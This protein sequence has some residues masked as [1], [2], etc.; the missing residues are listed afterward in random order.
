MNRTRFHFAYYILMLFTSVTLMGQEIESTI[1]DGS[2]NEYSNDQVPTSI[3][4]IVQTTAY[5]PI[6]GQEKVASDCLILLKN[7]GSLAAYELETLSH[8]WDLSF[9][10]GAYNK[11]DNHF[12]IENA[13]L[14]TLSTQREFLAVDV[15]TGKKYWK[16][17][18]GQQKE[19]TKRY[20]TDG[21]RLPIKGSLIYVA[22]NNTQLYAFNKRNGSLVWNYKLQ[23][24]YNNYSPVIN[25][26]Y[27]LIS[28]APWVYCFDARTGQAIWQRGFGNVPMYAQLQIDAEKAFT[29][30]ERNKI[31]ALD[32]ANN[33]AIDWEYET[34]HDSPRIKENTL[35]QNGVYYFAAR[36][37]GDDPATVTALNTADGQVVWKTV[38]ENDGEEID[39]FYAYND[40]IVGSTDAAENGFFI[41]DAKNGEQWK[42]ESPK[43]KVL[44][45]IFGMGDELYFITENFL[46]S[47]NLE[48]K[49]FDYR[50]FEFDDQGKDSFSLHFEIAKAEK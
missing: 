13:I 22:S 3:E 21:Q 20:V 50:A 29:A 1:D 4:E 2:S 36:K 17:E 7:D 27:L 35:L 43:E 12:R 37:N 31:Y 16:T 38:L 14:Y 41:I 39:T 19:I 28:N 25:D 18:I 49:K 48:R 40:L 23:F 46:V 26:N 11:M 45:N 24:P 15:N 33:A 6:T 42:I 10:D 47:F 44:S 9:D 5:K 8:K 34:E 32:I 30:S